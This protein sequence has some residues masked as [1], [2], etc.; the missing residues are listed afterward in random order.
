MSKRIPAHRSFIQ[1]VDGLLK[2]VQVVDFVDG[3]F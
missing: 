3:K 1:S 2:K